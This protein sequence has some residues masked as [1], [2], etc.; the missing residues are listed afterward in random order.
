MHGAEGT[1]STLLVTSLATLVLDSDARTIRGF[2]SLV[3]REWIAAGHSFWS[4]CNHG[5][6]AVGGVTGPDESPTFLLFLDCVWQVNNT[7][8]VGVFSSFCCLQILQQYP[9]SFEFT[10]EFLIF[11]FEHAYASE[12]GSFLGNCE[13]DKMQFGI[14]IDTVSLW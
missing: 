12:F 4:R 1:D 3:E 13:R 5:A 6:F 7:T 10:E 2:Q 9:C 8:F 14:K 11:L